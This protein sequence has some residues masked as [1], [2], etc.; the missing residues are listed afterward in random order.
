[1]E[2]IL[3]KSNNSN[4]FENINQEIII[5]KDDEQKKEEI[6]NKGE[7]RATTLYENNK[8]KMSAL[9]FV[10]YIYNIE[11]MFTKFYWLFLFIILGVI[12]T[13]YDLSILIILYILIFGIIYIRMF[14]Q[15]I[16]KLDN[17]TKKDTYFISKLIRYNLIEL[18]RH[19]QQNRYF[20]TLGYEYLLMVSLISYIL[21]YSFGIFHQ[22]QNGCD[23]VGNNQK[24]VW[25]GCDNRHKKIYNRDDNIFDCIAY[26][27]GFYS[28]CDHVFEEAWF[29]I[30]FAFLI[31]FD[32]YVLKLELI[33]NEKIKK[34]RKDYKYLANQNLQLKP[35]TYGEDNIF[36]NIRHFIKKAED[37]INNENIL[38]SQERIRQMEK[39]EEE[40]KNKMQFD[41]F[42]KLRAAKKIKRVNTK[43]IDFKIDTKND[44]EDTK[45]GKKLIDTFI[46][47]FEK[48]TEK[49]E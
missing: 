39:E 14:Y 15:I 16:I 19:E 30:F 38:N 49:K 36:M 45:I 26:L 11:I 40:R 46:N 29:H 47:M 8:K 17:F 5:E 23:Y 13:T 1:M 42:S 21:F 6:E 3:L 18:N 9:N 28:E 2:R 37:S 7:E 41:Y 31:S 32:V 48:S 20:R 12:F 35:L 44:D 33:I 4:I 10:Y 24:A 22:A 25:E 43:N 27:I 34:N